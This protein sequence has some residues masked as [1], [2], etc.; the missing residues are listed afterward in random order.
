M[1]HILRIWGAQSKAATVKFQLDNSLEADGIFGTKTIAKSKEIIMKIQK[2]ITDGKIAIDGL[3]GQETKDA[4]AR[5]QSEVGLPSDGI[6]GRNT[7]A[8]IRETIRK[9]DDWWGDNPVLLSKGICLQMRS[10]L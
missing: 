5:W 7:R 9:D 3:A 2:E 1:P 10:I 8:K 6:A 4:T